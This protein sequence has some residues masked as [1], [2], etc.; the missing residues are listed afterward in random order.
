MTSLNPRYLN[1]QGIPEPPLAGDEATTLFGALER[2]RHTLAWKCRGL[3]AAGMQAT[4][5]A[6]SVTLGGLLKHLAFCEVEKFQMDYL[7]HAD[8]GSPWNTA[9]W[10]SEPEWPWTSAAQD[11]PGE[12]MD[13][14]QREVARSREITEQALAGQ[15]LDSPVSFTTPDGQTPTLRR[16]VIDLVEEYARHVGHADLIRESIDGL[17]GEDAPPGT[18]LT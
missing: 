3:D 15:G 12:L 2:Q 17:V 14:W 9:P 4:F 11:S 6:S 18:P 5:G 16:L 1:D 8:P 13:L 10:E 7:G